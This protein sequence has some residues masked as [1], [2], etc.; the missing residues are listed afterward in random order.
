MPV[1]FRRIPKVLVAAAFIVL[2]LLP[3]FLQKRT[4]QTI[5]QPVD[6]QDGDPVDV[7]KVLPRGVQRPIDK[8]GFNAS[9]YII[10]L[11]N[12]ATGSPYSPRAQIRGVVSSWLN[13]VV[14]I[15]VGEQLHDISIPTYVRLFCTPTYIQDQHGNKVASE[16]V[17]MDLSREQNLGKKIAGDLIPKK[18]PNGSDFLALV[19]VSE[20]N[21]MTG[22]LIVGIGCS[23]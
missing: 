16:T 7:N 22:Y 12:N 2:I 6:Q 18:F 19:N 5:R 13:D 1:T 9:A 3:I 4:A 20:D 14:T 23:M 21:T 10:P 17:W 11:E 15:T 8:S